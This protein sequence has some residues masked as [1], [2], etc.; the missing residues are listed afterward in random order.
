MI[1]SDHVAG[2]SS[3]ISPGATNHLVS[4][5]TGPIELIDHNKIASPPPGPYLIVG[6]QL[7][8]IYELH[9]DHQGAFMT[10]IVSHAEL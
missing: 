7:W 10:S 6:R 9:D 1:F 5:G 8:E 3:N 4:L 2:T